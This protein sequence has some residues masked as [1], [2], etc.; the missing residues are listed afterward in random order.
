MSSEVKIDKVSNK[1]KLLFLGL[2]ILFTY[3]VPFLIVGVKFGFFKPEV[4]APKKLT[5]FCLLALVVIAFKFFGRAKELIDKYVKNT[6]LRKVLLF[7]RNLAIAI[8]II[9]VLENMKGSI[10]NLEFFVIT[11]LSSFT[12]GNLFFEDFKD[13]LKQ[14]EKWVAKQ[15]MLA[16]LKEYE[17]QKTKQTQV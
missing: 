1:K 6:I 8:V 15:E 17:E 9:V 5:M 14:D 16:T 10:D 13:C 3:L 7:S 12:I 4:S 11:I 2:S